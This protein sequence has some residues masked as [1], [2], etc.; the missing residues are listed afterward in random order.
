MTTIT[1]TAA[2]AEKQKN[3]NTASGGDQN[4]LSFHLAAAAGF[5]FSTTSS[6]ATDRQVTILVLKGDFLFPPPPRPGHYFTTSDPKPQK[7]LNQLRLSRQRRTR[8]LRR[9]QKTRARMRTKLKIHVTTTF[10][11][12]RPHAGARIHKSRECDLP[13]ECGQRMRQRLL[14]DKRTIWIHSILSVITTITHFIDTNIINMTIIMTLIIIIIGKATAEY[15]R[16]SFYL[17]GRELK[18]LKIKVSIEI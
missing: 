10:H 7:R 3:L 9:T 15:Y 13:F 4:C 1:T 18:L 6:K 5:N 12:T 8:R 11:S 14:H 16:L 2:A 17:T